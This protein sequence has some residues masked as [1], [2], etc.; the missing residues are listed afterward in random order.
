MARS[1]SWSFRSSDIL[2]ILFK[3][4]DHVAQGE[5]TWTACRK[6]IIH[7]NILFTAFS[8]IET[9]KV[10]SSKPQLFQLVLSLT[11]TGYASHGSSSE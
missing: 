4:F 5:S 10:F 11:A 6:P 8:M 1:K 3:I 7:T 2:Q 9:L